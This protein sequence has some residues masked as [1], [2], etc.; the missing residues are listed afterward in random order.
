ME[1]NKGTRLRFWAAKEHKQCFKGTFL[2]RR[3]E[4]CGRSCVWESEHKREIFQK[5][6]CNNRM[7]ANAMPSLLT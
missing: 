7:F 4:K 2:Q 3:G 1:K 5:D 6:E